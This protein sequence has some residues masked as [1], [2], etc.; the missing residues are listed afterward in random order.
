MKNLTGTLCWLLVFLPILLWGQRDTSRNNTP[1]PNGAEDLIEDFIQNG[2]AE[3]DFDFNDLFAE[4]E[5]RRDHPLNLNKASRY[6][7]EAL[8][9][10]SDIQINDFLNYRATYGDFIATEELQAIPSFDL[11]R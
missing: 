3:G 7:L 1:L 10:L 6:D 9:L 8:H 5:Y 2:D 11:T 4:L